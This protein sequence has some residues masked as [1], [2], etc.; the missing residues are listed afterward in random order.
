MSPTEQSGALICLKFLNLVC[1]K[2]GKA[3]RAAHGMNSKNVAR[4]IK[5]TKFVGFCFSALADQNNG[6]ENKDH[7]TDPH[8]ELGW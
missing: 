5:L 7:R 2:Q 1:V 6:D 8:E 3:F 4:S